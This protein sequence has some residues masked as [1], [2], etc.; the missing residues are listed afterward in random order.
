MTKETKRPTGFLYP[1]TVL[2]LIRLFP[3][4]KKKGHHI[5]EIRRVGYY[6]K[7]D[8]LDVIW[9]VDNSGEYNWTADHAWVMKHFEII[10]SPSSRSIYGIRK[11]VLGGFSANTSER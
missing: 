4:A 8:G 3:H 2:R 9:L 6:S 5:G 1:K 11:P 10:E 7:N